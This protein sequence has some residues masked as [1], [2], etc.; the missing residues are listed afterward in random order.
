MES[1]SETPE[2]ILFTANGLDPMIRWD[3]LTASMEQVG[4]SAPTVKITLGGSGTGV[5]AGGIAGTYYAYQRFLDKNGLV[6]NL[7][8]ISDAFV[9][10]KR[11]LVI[12]NAHNSTPIEVTT[13]SDHGINPG[14][15][16][17]VRIVGVG[18]NT[19]ANGLWTARAI[20]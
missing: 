8:P 6:S 14:T 3:G 11:T 5:T 13:S 1:F 9:A 20:T 17:V 7:S 2:G 16:A 10:V 15:S 19:A 4:L 18:G 12:T